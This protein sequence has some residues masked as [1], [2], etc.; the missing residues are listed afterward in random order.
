MAPL[1]HR[2]LPDHEDAGTDISKEDALDEHGEQ[3]GRGVGRSRRLMG[4]RRKMQ[5]AELTQEDL[6]VAMGELSRQL[7]GV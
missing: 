4:L 6:L 2:L 5:S 7:A 1:E 3:A